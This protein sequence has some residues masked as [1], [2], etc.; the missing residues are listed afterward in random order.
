M[1]MKRLLLALVCLTLCSCAEKAPDRKPV[2]PLTGQVLVDGQP[3]RR[4][5]VFCHDVKGMDGKQPTLSSSTTDQD[6]KFAMTTYET[7]DGVPQGE[8]VLTFEWYDGVPGGAPLP[9]KLKHRYADVKAS[10]VRATVKAGEPTDLGKVEL[11]TR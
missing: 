10:K 5:S 3:A 1:S 9:D 6:G 2:Y 4:V 8:Y 7:G 11:A